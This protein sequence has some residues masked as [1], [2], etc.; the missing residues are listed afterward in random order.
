MGLWIR[1]KVQVFRV[2]RQPVTEIEPRC[3]Y[4]LGQRWDEGIGVRTYAKCTALRI[5]HKNK[6]DYL[7]GQGRGYVTGS[8]ISYWKFGTGFTKEDGSIGTVG[9][10]LGSCL[11]RP[12]CVCGSCDVAKLIQRF[13]IRIKCAKGARRQWLAYWYCKMSV[14]ARCPVVNLLGSWNAAH[15]GYS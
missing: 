3:A 11:Q 7:I 14:D 1:D 8:L 5:L 13:P 12:L 6:A 10:L 2:C 9:L 4:L 15:A